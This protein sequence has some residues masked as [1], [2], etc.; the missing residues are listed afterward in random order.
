MGNNIFKIDK[1]YQIDK[2][3]YLYWPRDIVSV[4]ASYIGQDMIIELQHL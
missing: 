2:L 1:L 4:I 3:Q